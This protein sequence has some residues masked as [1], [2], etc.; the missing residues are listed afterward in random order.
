M[1]DMRPE[2][3]TPI[4]MFC[5][6]GGVGKTTC[7]ASTAIHYSE[8]GYRTLLVS[9]DPSPSLSDILETDVYGR[10]VEV[11]GQPGLYAV[12]LDYAG[13]KDLWLERFGGEVYEVVSSFLP[14]G[15]EVLQYI[16][17]APGISEEF[18][19][20]YIYDFYVGGEYDLIVWD[21]APAGGTLSL[22]KLQETFY[23]HMGEA[24]GLYLRLKNTLDRLSGQEKKDPLRLIKEWEALARNVLEMVRAPTTMAYIVTIPESLG[25]SQTRRIWEEL[26]RFGV[27][28]AGIII[29]TLITEDQEC[30]R[31][32]TKRKAMQQ[33]YVDQIKEEYQEVNILTLPLAEFEVKGLE[34]LRRVEKKLFSQPGI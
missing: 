18:A 15:E 4:K 17:G 20:S 9:T 23:R 6:K 27:N 28:I 3:G 24:A 25:V 1:R 16:S 31:L 11:A 5:G 21:T 33:T 30:S 13:I 32:L 29:N 12:E 19:L 8:Q 2:R 10:V 22:L 34:P 14:V 7:S 26:G